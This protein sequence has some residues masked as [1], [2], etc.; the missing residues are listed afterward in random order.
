[1]TE[2]I[3]EAAREGCIIDWYRFSGEIGLTQETYKNIQDAVAKV[4]KEK[5][6][7]IKN[8]L[9]EEVII[10]LEVLTVNIAT[11]LEPMI[12]CCPSIICP[13]SVIM[14]IYFFK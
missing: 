8:E 4:G 9:P 6:K 1:M 3:L 5:L 14:L 12:E 7:P 10:G 2:Y 11:I 13:P